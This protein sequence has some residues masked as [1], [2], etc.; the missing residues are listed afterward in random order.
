MGHYDEQIEASRH[1]RARTRQRAL[2]QEVQ[3]GR[4]QPILDASHL[5]DLHTVT[6][7]REV[8]EVMLAILRDLDSGAVR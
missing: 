2:I 1:E 6:L 8:F 7:P 5:C 3:E 4:Y